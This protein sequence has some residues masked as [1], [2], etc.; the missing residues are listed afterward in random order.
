MQRQ[1]SSNFSYRHCA[2]GNRALRG[3]SKISIVSNVSGHG[4]LPRQNLW[5]TVSDRSLHGRT[6]TRCRNSCLVWLVCTSVRGT[7]NTD[8]RERISS[9]SLALTLAEIR[10]RCWSRYRCR[11]SPW[12]WVHFDRYWTV[13]LSSA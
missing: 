12:T 7:T 5:R 6:L 3:S 9:R 11:Y 2:C 4:V 8:V 1:L 13:C 10:C